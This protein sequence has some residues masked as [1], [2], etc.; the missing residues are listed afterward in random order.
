MKLQ[1]LTPKDISELLFQGID[2]SNF[3]CVVT[4]LYGKIIFAN[5]GASKIFHYPQEYIIGKSAFSFFSYPH[6]LYQILKTQKTYQGFVEG[7]THEGLPFYLHVEIAPLQKDE[8]EVG[9]IYLG[10]NVLV[11]KENYQCL[12]IATFDTLTELPHERAFSTLINTYI[13]RYK[14]PFTLLIVD[15]YGFSNLALIYDLPFLDTLLK[16]VTQ[17]LKSILPPQTFIGRKESDEF[18]IVLFET[19]KEKIGTLIMD[20]FECFYNPFIIDEKPILLTVNIGASSYPE[21]GS[22]FEELFSKAFSALEKAKKK[23]ENTFSVYEKELEEEVKAFISQRE[24]VAKLLSERKALLYGQPYF[25]TSNKEIGGIEILLR[26]KENEKVDSIATIIDF[27]ESSGLISKVENYLFEEIK[28]I[29]PKI[30][31]PLSINLSAKSFT[32]PEI[33]SKLHDLR[34]TLGYPFVCE[35]TE[36]LFLEKDTVKIISKIKDLDIQIALDDF[37]TGYSSFSHIETLPIDF[38]KIDISFIRRMLD[39]PKALAIVQT[40]I[41]LAK[42]LNIKTIAEGVENEEQF[43]ILRLLMCDYVQG[44]YLNEPVP[45]ESFIK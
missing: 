38:I 3:L 39:E 32:S 9:F 15:I 36:R 45:L 21:D 13:E 16:E 41:D 11:E 18:L 27:L 34:K 42:R 37:G 25:S 12:K 1:N 43:R 8:E 26:I 7:R 22:T 23:G 19:S 10:E 31:I 35:I 20:I 40:I 2:N 33:F 30:R 17:R 24:K 6:N 14:Q 29:G 4:D 44:Y 5:K 28:K